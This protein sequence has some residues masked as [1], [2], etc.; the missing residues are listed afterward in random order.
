MRA[1]RI[2]LARM[3]MVRPALRNEFASEVLPSDRY[4]ARYLMRAPLMPRSMNSP[5]M[6][7]GIIAMV[8]CP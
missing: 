1:V 7:M 2:T 5:A 4:C 3:L 8:I 6:D